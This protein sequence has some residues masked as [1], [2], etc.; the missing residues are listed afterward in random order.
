[1]ARDVTGRTVLVWLASA[2]VLT[3]LIGLVVGLL[4]DRTF[5]VKGPRENAVRR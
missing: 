3:A 1:M 2:F 4:T 5:P